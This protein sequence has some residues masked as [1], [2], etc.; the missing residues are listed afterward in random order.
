MD[1][2]AQRQE[3]Q[4]L[5]QQAAAINKTLAQHPHLQVPNTIMAEDGSLPHNVVVTPADLSHQHLVPGKDGGG[6]GGYVTMLE[7]IHEERS[8]SPSAIITVD[9]N[10]LTGTTFHHNPYRGA[11][12]TSEQIQEI[13]AGAQ[14]V[15]TVDMGDVE[16]GPGQ[17]Q[18]T[19]MNIN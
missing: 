1:E 12:L 13:M 11:D 8:K 2:Q 5:E 14:V 18:Y 3:Q 15:Q 17:V 19:Y 4:I 16:M 6:G 10:T 9:K 7:E